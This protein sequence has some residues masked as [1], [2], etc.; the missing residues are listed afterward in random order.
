MEMKNFVDAEGS[1]VFS[2]I[3]ND[4]FKQSVKSD[5]YTNDLT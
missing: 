5:S 3:K 4:A 2:D 1:R